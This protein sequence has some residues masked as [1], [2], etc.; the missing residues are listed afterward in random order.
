MH[1]GWGWLRHQN[2]GMWAAYL[3]SCHQWRGTSS[4]PRKGGLRRLKHSPMPISINIC[5]RRTAKGCCQELRT[6]MFLSDLGAPGPHIQHHWQRLLV[7]IWN[8][9][10]KTCF[11]LKEPLELKV[12]IIIVDKHNI[13]ICSIYTCKKYYGFL[14]CTAKNQH[15]HA[16]SEFLDQP[17]AAVEHSIQGFHLDFDVTCTR[18]HEVMKHHEALPAA[19]WYSYV[20]IGLLS[21]S[22]SCQHSTPH[23][24]VNWSFGLDD[25]ADAARQIDFQ[26]RASARISSCSCCYPTTILWPKTD[27]DVN[28]SSLRFL[29]HNK[30]CWF[31]SSLFQPKDK[32]T[33]GLSPCI[34]FQNGHGSMIKTSN[35][36]FRDV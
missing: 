25:N 17:R 23:V 9:E 18:N 35:N 28:K 8:Y 27:E 2:Q 24:L 26:C 34:F 31:S 29:K 5:I 15:E 36:M 10:T 33:R 32:S 19:H 20:F 30:H 22:V 6:S 3:R 13:Y 14:R 16:A 21:N 11:L 12:F 7:S 1:L 4:S